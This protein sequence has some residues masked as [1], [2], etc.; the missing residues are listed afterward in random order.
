VTGIATGWFM[1]NIHRD[2]VHLLEMER[3]TIYGD[4]PRISLNMRALMAMEDHWKQRAADTA[5]LDIKRDLL[6]QDLVRRGIIREP[7]EGPPAT[8]RKFNRRSR[9][10]KI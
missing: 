5:S 4:S 3:V 6:E 2:R 8:A 9:G 10:K 7:D 1:S